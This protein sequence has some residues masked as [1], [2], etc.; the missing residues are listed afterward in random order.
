MMEMCKDSDFNEIHFSPVKITFLH[1]LISGGSAM[2]EIGQFVFNG[3]ASSRRQPLSFIARRCVTFYENF[4][5]LR[6][7]FTDPDEMF[8]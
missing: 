5:E 3:K 6:R 4:I 2:R 1:K 7:T 8:S